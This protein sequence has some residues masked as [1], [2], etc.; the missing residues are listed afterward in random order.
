YCRH[1]SEP[2]GAGGADRCRYRSA[3]RSVHRV[4][5]R[6]DDRPSGRDAGE[7]AFWSA[8][9]AGGEHAADVRGESGDRAGRGSAGLVGR[10]AGGVRSGSGS[11][12]G[13][14]P[15]R[16][17]LLGLLLLIYTGIEI[18]LGAWLTLYMRT[19]T[20]MGAASAALV[21][22]G[23]WLALTSGRALGVRLGMRMSAA[24]L[25]RLC[26]GGVLLGARSEE[27]TSE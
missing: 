14:L 19:S 17:W 8:R 9:D 20:A 10:G 4:L 2:A 12:R 6:R 13:R 16:R 22:S 26:L 7:P 24:G 5:N 1:W 3:R 25:L 11:A 23:F 21:V 15:A 18:G 27:H